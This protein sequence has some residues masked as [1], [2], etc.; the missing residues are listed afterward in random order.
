MDQTNAQSTQPVMSTQTVDTVPPQ[1]SAPLPDSTPPT[2]P[3]A[4]Q[5]TVPPSDNSGTQS[6]PSKTGL[7]AGLVVAALLAGAATYFVF[8][9]QGSKASQPVE[10]AMPV[11]EEMT[12][13]IYQEPVE[14]PAALEDMPPSEE[15]EEYSM[16]EQAKDESLG[17]EEMMPD[18]EWSSGEGSL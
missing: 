10:T 2:P 3:I 11:R 14:D 15:T 8:M 18:E 6:A 1:P 16:T 7:V 17:T 12:D 9:Y 13:E 5:V 4:P